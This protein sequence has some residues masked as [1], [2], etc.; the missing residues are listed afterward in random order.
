MGLAIFFSDHMSLRSSI[1][2]LL[3]KYPD[4]VVY[5]VLFDSR[6]PGKSGR[7]QYASFQK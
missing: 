2:E 5:K 3:T 4:K 6:A 1:T 7:S